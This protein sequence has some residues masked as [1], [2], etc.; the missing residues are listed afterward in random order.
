MALGSVSHTGCQSKG[1]RAGSKGQLCG[2]HHSGRLGRTERNLSCKDVLLD[3][4]QRLPYQ[5]LHAQR[6]RVC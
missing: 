5:L 6:V 4:I 2:M 1:L 3:L